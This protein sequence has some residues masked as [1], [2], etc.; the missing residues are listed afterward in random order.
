VRRYAIGGSD[1]GAATGDVGCYLSNTGNNSVAAALLP[2]SQHAH[3]IKD[4]AAAAS[5]GHVGSGISAV[6]PGKRKGPTLSLGFPPAAATVNGSIDAESTV[7]NIG[8]PGG[9]TDINTGR[10]AG[11]M[12]TE[13]YYEQAY[14]QPT[15]ADQFDGRNPDE[16]QG[17]WQGRRQ[18]KGPLDMSQ[19]VQR[20][21]N[22]IEQQQAPSGSNN[23]RGTDVNLIYHKN[24]LSEHW[25][26]AAVVVHIVQFAILLINGRPMLPDFIFAAILFCAVV[27]TFLLVYAR[28]VVRKRRQTHRFRLREE[29][30]PE[31]ETD[32]VPPAA[33]YCL[34]IAAMLEGIS[35]ALFS[36]TVAGKSPLVGPPTPAPTAAPAVSPTDTYSFSATNRYGLF[37][38]QDGSQLQ[39]K[40]AVNDFITGALSSVYRILTATNGDSGDSNQGDSGGSDGYNDSSTLLETLRFASITLLAFHRTIRPA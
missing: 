33:V 40:I 29:H 39:D 25:L 2:G 34:S 30:T 26:Y 35:L 18:G 23:D 14:R 9:E 15:E 20:D 38:S 4:G 37:E 11:S 3:S 19:Y 24:R 13:L 17:R 1:K 21:P 28:W 7:A 16:T 36:A 6:V 12:N 22:E 5:L 10:G 27:V 8:G 31:E 32:F